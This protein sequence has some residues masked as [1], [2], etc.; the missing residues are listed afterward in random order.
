M[1]PAAWIARWPH[2]R[3]LVR[4]SWLTLAPEQGA[5][6][7]GPSHRPSKQESPPRPE[8]GGRS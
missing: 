4:H 7:Q 3:R 8:P 2:D 6:Q 5:W 1:K